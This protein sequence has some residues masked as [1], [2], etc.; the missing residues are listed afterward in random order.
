MRNNIVTVDVFDRMVS[1]YKSYIQNTT[2]FHCTDKGVEAII[3]ESLVAKESLIELMRNHKDWNENILSIVL[4]GEQ[5]H[6]DIDVDTA[7]DCYLRFADWFNNS[8]DRNCDFWDQKTILKTITVGDYK[9]FLTEGDVNFVNQK[10][11]MLSCDAPLKVNKFKVAVGMKRS[12]AVNKVLTALG[13]REKYLTVPYRAYRGAFGQLTV[14]TNEFAEFFAKYGDAIN[15]L[16]VPS[17]VIISAYPLDFIRSSNG[18]GW[19]S[20]HNPNRADYNGCNCSG[21]ISYGLDT[22]T[23]CVYT[24]K[25]IDEG[26]FYPELDKQTRAMVHISDDRKWFIMDGV[27]PEKTEEKNRK[28]RGIFQRVMSECTGEPNLWTICSDYRERPS[29]YIQ[30][31][32]GAT[33]YP[34]YHHASGNCGSLSFL[35]GYNMNDVVYDFKYIIAGAKPISTTSGRRHSVEDDIEGCEYCQNC[36]DDLGYYNEAVYSEYHGTYGCQHCMVWSDYDHDYFYEDEVIYVESYGGTVSERALENSGDFAYCERCGEWTYLD[37][38]YVNGLDAYLCEDCL[39]EAIRDG[40]V[41]QCSDCGD[42]CLT[43]TIVEFEGEYYCPNCITTCE[44]CGCIVPKSIAH[45]SYGPSCRHGLVYR[46]SD[47]YEQSEL[48]KRNKEELEQA[49]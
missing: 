4:N 46:C 44:D 11:Q 47:C 20:C 15:P 18:A 12:K 25:K 41:V 7:F 27:Y 14:E 45:R 2:D 33:C 17:L 23:L 39:N 30:T 9:Q 16:E 32:D 5:L 28:L 40:E 48:D 43:D 1:E 38:S 3:D 42:F 19:G 13:L 22:N 36:G 34:D 37:W 35:N 29:A 6:R 8:I 10:M 49:S 21:G 31:G 24:L 26:E